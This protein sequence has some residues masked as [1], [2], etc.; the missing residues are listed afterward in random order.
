MIILI[1]VV[2]ILITFISRFLIIKQ[3][4][5]IL[6]KQTESKV[7]L[8]N[9]DSFKI[10]LIITY[11]D[12]KLGWSYIRSNNFKDFK[13]ILMTEIFFFD[14][15][16]ATFSR[17]LY[18]TVLSFEEN[19][20]ILVMEN[21]SAYRANKEPKPVLNRESGLPWEWVKGGLQMMFDSSYKFSIQNQ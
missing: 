15:Q 17:I 14:R 13:K 7:S 12:L 11:S 6:L 3:H 9:K 2:S 4:V 5:N 19:G 8:D 16:V 10:L 1:T 20:Y 18:N 21:P